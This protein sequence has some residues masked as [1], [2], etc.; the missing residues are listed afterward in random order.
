MN[1]RKMMSQ[2]QK[3]ERLVESVE[4]LQKGMQQLVADVNSVISNMHQQLSQT[5]E[6]LNGV[7]SLLGVEKVAA[8]ITAERAAR[9]KEDAEKRKAAT[10]EMLEQGKL[11]AT[12]T[13]AADGITVFEELDKDGNVIPPGYSS[14]PMSRAPEALKTAAVGHKV[15]EVIALGEDKA[16]IIESYVFVTKVVEAAAESTTATA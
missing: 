3:I 13:V 16:R 8:A 4:E 7:V 15:G 11:A 5:V 2:R 10:K 9:L 6:T 14:V 1:E 12:D